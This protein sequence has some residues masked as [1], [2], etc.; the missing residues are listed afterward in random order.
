M[1]AKP[2]GFQV[3]LLNLSDT[4]SNNLLQTIVN[5]FNK[6]TSWLLINS[7]TG[8][9]TQVARVK[10]E[11]PNQLDYIGSVYFPAVNAMPVFYMSA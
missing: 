7:D 4:L 3:Q 6:T 11:Y 10:A 5:D 2:I 8:T 1:R 9:R